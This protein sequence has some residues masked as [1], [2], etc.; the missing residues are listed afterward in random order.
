MCRADEADDL[1]VARRDGANRNAAF[2]PLAEAVPARSLEVRA[3]GGHLFRIALAGPDQQGIL[4]S[5]DGP[6][7]VRRPIS[8]QVFPVGHA[9]LHLSG[10]PFLRIGLARQNR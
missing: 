10:S 4:E 6:L 9:Q 3:G 2:L 8:G 7:S 1:D 5:G